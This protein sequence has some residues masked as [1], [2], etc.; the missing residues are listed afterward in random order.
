MKKW[1]SVILC[2]AMVLTFAVGCGSSE[3]EG[4]GAADPTVIMVAHWYAEGHPIYEAWAAFETELEEATA[5]AFDV[6]VYPNAQL[7]SEDTFIDSVNQG[8]VQIGTTGTM[9][10]KYHEAIYA[11][12]TPF[13]FSEWDEA[14]DVFNGEIG[15]SLAEGF[16]GSS[17]M[18]LIGSMVNGFREFS[19]N[20]TMYSLDEFKGMRMRVPNVPNYIEMVEALG[21]SPIAMSLTDLFTALEQN[22]V[23]GQDN[24]YPTDLSNSFYEVQKYILESRHMFTPANIVI[25]TAFYEGLSD[26]MRA[27]LDEALTNCIAYNWELSQDADLEAKEALIGHGVEV[28]VPDEAY[29]QQ[30]KDAMNPVYDWYAA[31]I[32][33]SQEF[34]EAVWAY[35]GK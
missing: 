11:Q 32:D 10:A 13:L 27:A 21:A 22:A 31:E 6:Q 16:N 24:P 20:K 5:G 9:I 1:L 28:T 7:G 23:D 4:E 17:N 35:Q 8:T 14:Y 29:R 3:G 26:D 15:A 30:L 25:N 19:S 12:E 33:G 34:I 18:T 2:I